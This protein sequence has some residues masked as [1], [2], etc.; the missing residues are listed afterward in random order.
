ME[1]YV[2]RFFAMIESAR[3]VDAYDKIELINL[4]LVP[5]MDKKSI[6]KLVNDYEI[7]Y[8]GGLKEKP[9]VDEERIKKD[10]EKLAKLLDGGMV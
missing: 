2:S 1:M 8:N 5:N 9:K 3:R 4:L 6:E 10:R 7:I